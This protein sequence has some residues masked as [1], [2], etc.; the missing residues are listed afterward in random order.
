MPERRG[1]Q[2]ANQEADLKVA[3]TKGKSKRAV[4]AAGGYEMQSKGADLPSLR[5]GQ[6]RWPCL[7]QGRCEMQTPFATPKPGR[8][9]EY[10][11]WRWGQRDSSG[12]DAALRMT[13]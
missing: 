1:L 9:A 7:W 3:A 6:E 10:G 12:R 2:N 11:I 5:S 4:P 13:N 8:G